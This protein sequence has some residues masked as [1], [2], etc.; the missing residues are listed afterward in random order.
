MD[1]ERGRQQK[2]KPGSGINFAS[3]LRNR[4]LGLALLLVFSLVIY[5]PSFRAPFHFDDFRHILNNSYI[6]L[7]SL[8]APAIRGAAFQDFRQNR[9]L[10]NLTFALNYYFNLARPFGYHLVNFILHFLSGVCLWF[11]L[12]R[13]FFR[14]WRNA[15]SARTTSLLA[16]A[17]W[18]AHPLNTQ[19]VTYI[20]QRQTVMAG[21]FSLLA[22]LCYEL[23]RSQRRKIFFAFCVLCALAAMLSKETA[24]PLP[25]LIFLYELCFFQQGK[26][27]WVS[28]NWK[29]LAGLA[30]FYFLL[31]VFVLRGPMLGKLGED[32][33]ADRFNRLERVLTAPR[34]LIQYLGLVIFPAGNRL[35][36]EHEVEVSRS[37]LHPVVTLPAML[38]VLALLG[39]A[40]FRVRKYPLAGFA[41][42]WYFGQLLVE[43]LPLPID[44]MNEHRLY[45][46]MIPVIAGIALAL[47]MALKNSKTALV[48]AALSCLCYGVLSRE[49]NR[50]WGSELSLWQDA[51]K[52]APGESRAWGNYCVYLLELDQVERA[53]KSCRMALE[54]D[55]QNIDAHFNFGIC[56]SSQGRYQEAER[57]FFQTLSLDPQ[58]GSAY[59]HLGLVKAAQGDLAAARSY[60]TKTMQMNIPNARVYF[61]LGDVYEKWDE[62]E[63]ALGAYSRALAMRPEWA[64]ARARAAAILAK[65][66]RCNEALGLLKASPVDDDSFAAVAGQCHGE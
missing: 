17:L 44:L 7:T 33:A 11:L 59:F 51:V 50:V 66:G 5:L 39:L 26:A 18:L 47:T 62:P 27:G 22:L 56:L 20:V 6:R 10:S 40:F 63:N 16:A 34:V 57:E 14:R 64:E 46:A 35:S 29:W 45:L 53:V 31:M 13:I 30:L 65:E 32:L 43:S 21:C 36:L 54:R 25:V 42:F 1:P 52:K 38:L 15:A 28:R 4:L 23:A 2:I 24:Y 19:A 41:V 48:L 12:E 3:N 55:P 60:F 37:L 9:P 58:Y 49:R 8:T 61:N